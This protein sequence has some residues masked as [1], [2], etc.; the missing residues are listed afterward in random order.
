MAATVPVVD[1]ASAD[2]PDVAGVIAPP[3]L[4]YAA[5]FGAGL[6]L[7]RLAS[8]PTVRLPGQR[9]LGA[10]LLLGGL[11]LSAWGFVTMRRAGTPVIPTEPTT[12]L[13][14]EGPF[15]YT[16]N[17]GYLGMAIAY[18]GLALTLG[19]FGP[20]LCLPGAVAVMEWGVIGREERYLERKFGPA[21][22]AYRAAVPR[23]LW[24]F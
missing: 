22:R 11:G 4:I 17:P 13:V 3:P 9:A 15:R 20:L 10:G 18:K 8:L 7:D 14:S 23:W 12:A 1:I 5:A 6:L 24:K 21:Y 2:R 19:R 16:R